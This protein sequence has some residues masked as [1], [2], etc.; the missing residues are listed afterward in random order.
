MTTISL[1][2]DREASARQ[3]WGVLATALFLVLCA[4]WTV[5]SLHF[6][7]AW[8]KT[9]TAYSVNSILGYSETER[10]NVV[11]KE[12]RSFLQQIAMFSGST[13]DVVDKFY[14]VRPAY[15]YVAALLAPLFGITGSALAMNLLGWAIAAFCAWSLALRLFGDPLAGLL[16]VAF[17]ATGM[18]FVVHVTDYSAHLLAFSTYY[19]G[20]VILYR[21]GVWKAPGRN[22]TVHLAIGAY[23][24]L[25]CLTYNVGLALLFAYIVIAVRHNRL[26]DIAIASI[27]A[28]SAQY[29]WVAVLNLGYALKS[30]DWAWYNLYGNEGSYLSESIRE[31]LRLWSA[32]VEGLRAT[33]QVILEFLSFEFPLTVAAGIV[34]VAAFFWRDRQ[35]LF[36]LFV[37]FALPIA[38]AMAYAQRAGAR[39]YLVFGISLIL[40][41]AL[42]G[43]LARAMRGASRGGRAA[44]IVAALVLIGG[45]ILWSGAQFTGYLGPLRAYYTGLDHNIADFTQ[46]PIEVISL[47]NEEPRPAWFGGEAQFDHLGIYEAAGPEQTPS[48]FVRRVAV[49]LGS[50][51]LISAYVVLLIASVGVLYGWPA[52]RGALMSLVFF[53][54]VPSVV[55]AA[56]VTNTIR[57]VPIDTAGPGARC[58]TMHYSVHLSDDF[59]RRLSEAYPAP[60]HLE[61]FFRVVGETRLPQ[62]KLDGNDFAINAGANEG[63]WLVADKG[64]RAKFLAATT[65]QLT[66][67]YNGDVSY[68]G[69]QRNGLPGRTLAFDG[70]ETK[71]TAAVLPALEVRTVVDRGVPILIGF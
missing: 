41:V 33:I 66:Y 21:S 17:V 3:R 10:A 58:A 2:T 68:L 44:A 13:T 42:G 67:S 53:Y 28:L 71:A 70:C 60:V 20:V 4:L 15:A 7:S 8:T 11:H 25:C 24:A 31:W 51:A 30:G 56:T 63:Q 27:I 23:I 50:R 69:W 32:P 6:G 39:G 48:S 5:G 55:M 61:L 52:W 12:N 37:L 35:R 29:A 47:T 36:I 57:F 43:L 18:G 54:F 26:S 38:G 62:F 16:A 65:L 45:Q 49:S 19:L 1:S 14:V 22:R 34:A 9:G 64:W 59:R 40:Y 46:R